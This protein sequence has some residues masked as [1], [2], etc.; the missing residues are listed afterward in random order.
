MIRI[1][2]LYFL[3]HF[4]N[5]L[6]GQQNI[7][8]RAFINGLEYKKNIII[9]DSIT[10]NTDFIDIYTKFFALHTNLALCLDSTKKTK[11]EYLFYFSPQPKYVYNLILKDSANNFIE[12]K[13]L[14]K[15]FFAKSQRFFEQYL[16]RYENEGFPFVEMIL[17][18]INVT[19]SDT[20]Y[21]FYR[22]L[23]NKYFTFDS[24]DIIGN[25]IVSKNFLA[26]YTGIIPGSKYEE[27]KIKRFERLI[28]ELV[29]VREKKKSDLYFIDSKAKL[30][31]YLDKQSANN[32]SGLIGISNGEKNQL[33]FNGD[34]AVSLNN[35]FKHAEIFNIAWKR[36]NDQ[37][38]RLD[39]SFAYPYLFNTPVGLMT[40]FNLHKQDSS[41]LNSQLR[42][43]LMFYTQGFNGMSVYYEQRQTSVLKYNVSNLASINN[44]LIGLNFIYNRLN[45]LVLPD[46]GY[47]FT[48]DMAYGRRSLLKTSQIPDSV[49]QLLS[50]NHEQWRG[51]S[52]IIT[53][54]P[55]MRP[56]FIKLKCEGATLSSSNFK[57]EL[58]RL[59]GSQSIR[60]FDEESLYASSYL[61]I[62][63]EWRMSLDNATQLFAFYDKLIYRSFIYSDNPWGMGLGAEINT[64][65]GL[66]FISY[67]LGSQFNQSLSLRNSKIHFGYKNRF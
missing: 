32:F 50:Q 56:F 18:S 15:H 55:L 33:M 10:L 19:N 4:S 52:S 39:L 21:L 12:K 57:N 2:L 46:K 26:V 25:N 67:A 45:Q 48:I 22:L 64:S 49:F 41:Y 27:K 6:F 8:V 37:S 1:V 54:I 28:N 38:Q 5:T 30:R 9:A 29:F 43:G 58:F 59:G 3:I 51:T 34:L 16:V 47:F 7:T 63:G 44:N 35:I 53:F 13:I 40:K 23:K 17:D 14:K 11:S 20:L 31:I 24:L 60:G 65:A 42:G 66:F 62:S 36:N 61:L